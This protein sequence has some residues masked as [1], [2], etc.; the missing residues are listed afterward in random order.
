[1]I[2]SQVIKVFGLVYTSEVYFVL[3]V[4]SYYRALISSYEPFLF[5]NI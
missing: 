3:T 4:T 2:L 5:K 1:M